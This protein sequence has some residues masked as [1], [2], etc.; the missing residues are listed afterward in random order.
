MLMLPCGVTSWILTTDKWCS[1]RWKQ[2]LSVH[3][4]TENDHTVLLKFCVNSTHIPQCTGTLLDQ[5]IPL[6][7]KGTRLAPKPTIA[8]FSRISRNNEEFFQETSFWGCSLQSDVHLFRPQ[9]CYLRHPENDSVLSM[10]KSFCMPIKAKHTNNNE[11][12]NTKKP[13]EISVYQI[14]VWVSK[15]DNLKKTSNEY[16]RNS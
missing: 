15:N 1:D 14:R 5:V 10:P 8:H 12:S 6:R 9:T 11:T 4:L 16:N 2:I 3:N 7:S 13:I